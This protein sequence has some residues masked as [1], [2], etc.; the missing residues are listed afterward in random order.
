ME[1]GMP[2]A[3]IHHDGKRLDDAAAAGKDHRRG[4]ELVEMLPLDWR[5]NGT[6]GA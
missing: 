3:P 1:P 5:W 4:T 2:S 6:S